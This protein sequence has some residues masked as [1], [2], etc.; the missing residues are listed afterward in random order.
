MALDG[1]HVADFEMYK[2]QGRAVRGLFDAATPLPDRQSRT[3]QRPPAL[4]AG[5][6]ASACRYEINAKMDGCFE[7][8]ASGEE[9]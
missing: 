3:R 4:R 2:L 9:R 5:T 8:D 6:G 7:K 1:R